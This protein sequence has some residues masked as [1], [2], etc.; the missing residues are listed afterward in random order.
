MQS[1]SCIINVPHLGIHEVNRQ[2]EDCFEVD[3][4]DQKVLVM[5]SSKK[6]LI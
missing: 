3:L 4:I 1:V 6:Y 2:L 5:V